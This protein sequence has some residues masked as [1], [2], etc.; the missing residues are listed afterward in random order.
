M[1]IKLRIFSSPSK[2]PISKC[3]SN[4][5]S[6]SRVHYGCFGPRPSCKPTLSMSFDHIFV[7]RLL[8]VSII[9]VLIYLMGHVGKPT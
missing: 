6:K 3:G 5:E 9:E 7:T 1:P 2:K 8:K 4:L